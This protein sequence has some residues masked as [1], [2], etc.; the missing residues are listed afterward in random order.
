[1]AVSTW[2]ASERWAFQQ[3]EGKKWLSDILI[4]TKDH[5]LHTGPVTRITLSINSMKRWCS[6]FLNYM[7]RVSHKAGDLLPTYV[8]RKKA[9]ASDTNPPRTEEIPAS[10]PTDAMNP[11]FRATTDIGNPRPAQISRTLSMPNLV[12]PPSETVTN[13]AA[14]SPRELWD[15]AFSSVL[16]RPSIS[17]FAAITASRSRTPQPT[18][19][20][21]LS[22][23]AQFGHS[24]EN[25][26]AMLKSR[27]AALISE[28]RPLKVTQDLAAHEALVRH[29]QFS[30]DGNHLATSRYG[31]FPS[32]VYLLG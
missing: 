31:A 3:H 19:S 21:S 7:R 8:D 23:G 30:P 24:E 15:K 6:R 27:I 4:E 12:N 13:G 26:Q 29:I 17:Q 22:F 1:M 20:S 32:A 2:F 16:T 14:R 10:T 25:R 5:I 11:L 9:T 18:A 28:L